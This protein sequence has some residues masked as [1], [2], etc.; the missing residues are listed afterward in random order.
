MNKKVIAPEMIP[1]V[2]TDTVNLDGKDYMIVNDAMFTFYKRSM[3]EL[4]PFFYAL[5]DEKKILG[6]KCPKCGL[7]RVPV[8]MTRCPDC[9]FVEMETVEVSQVGE[10]LSTPPI[11]YFAN[12]LFTQQVPFGRG[13]LVLDGTDTAMSVNF[14]TTKGILVPGIVKKGTKMKVVFRD[15]REGAISDIFCVPASELTPEQ[16]AKPGLLESE[17]DWDTV[18]EPELPAGTQA[19]VAKYSAVLAELKDLAAAFNTCQRARKD[20][21]DWYRNILVKTT[22][23]SFTLA[24]SDGDMAVR[25]AAPASPDFVMVLPDLS[26]LLNGLAYKGSLTQAIMSKD[27]W[28]SK[29]VEFTTIFK[30][31][32]MARSLART[33]KN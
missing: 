29:N 19:D 2:G 25:D 14:Y 31:E 6:T 1:D 7:V 18:R 17:I 33:K 12:A 21:A 30:L 23:G 32:R 10:M 9:N 20:I 27:L 16:L 5:R 4:S 8:F 26:V 11:T 15:N 22:G 13:R 3:G 28:I 24:L